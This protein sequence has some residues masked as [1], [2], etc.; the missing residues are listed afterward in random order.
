MANTTIE[1]QAIEAVIKFEG[2]KKYA[3][4]VRYN[5]REGKGIDVLVRKNV[6]KKYIEVKGNSKDRTVGGILLHGT[7]KKKLG[8]LWIYYVT[9]VG[10]SDY[11]K[12]KIFKIRPTRKSFKPVIKYSLS[13]RNML[14]GVKQVK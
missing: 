12:I 1:N 13:T 8:K 4:D 3:R 5:K 6:R 2:G 9:N 10:Q 14:N 7:A 11:S